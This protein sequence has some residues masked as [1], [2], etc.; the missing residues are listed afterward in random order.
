M[1]KAFLFILVFVIILFAGGYVFLQQTTTPARNT[2]QSD[3]G[4]EI[5]RPTK[6]QNLDTVTAAS[7]AADTIP[8]SWNTY[9]STEYRFS[10]SYP[11]SVLHATTQEGERFY[12]LGA[13]QSQ[14]TELYDGISVVIRSGSLSGK[15]FAQWVDENYADIKNDPVQPRV[16]EKKPVVIAGKEGIAFTVSS[17]GDRVMIYLPKGNNQFLEISNGTVE[18]A[19]SQQ[20]FQKTVDQM[21]S[22][23]TYE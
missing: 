4:G 3:A 8:T 21:L 2:S 20:G 1:S 16:G 19:D 15:S 14:G 7:K 11:S 6:P 22:S 17:L 18:P 13:S 5:P 9:T 23:I 12:Q 10:I